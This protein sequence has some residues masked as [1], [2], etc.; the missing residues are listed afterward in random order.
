MKLSDKTPQLFPSLEKPNSSVLIKNCVN[1]LL[2]ALTA[3]KAQQ[4]FLT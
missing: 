3:S 2:H 1:T 4:Y